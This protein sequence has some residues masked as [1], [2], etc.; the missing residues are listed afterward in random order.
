MKEF[1][2]NIHKPTIGG[3]TSAMFEKGETANPHPFLTGAKTLP[4]VRWLRFTSLK[5]HFYHLSLLTGRLIV[6]ATDDSAAFP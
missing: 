5:N 1:D 6:S 3:V 4:G 2:R